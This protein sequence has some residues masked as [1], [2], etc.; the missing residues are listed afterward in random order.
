MA[1][2]ENWQSR[3]V[4]P[5][6]VTVGE[7]RIGRPIAWGGMGV[8]YLAENPLLG[9]RAAAKVLREEFAGE[10][11]IV[12]RFLEEASAASK[13]R[14]PN[15]VQIFDLVA[16]P[17]GRPCIVMEY[18]EGETLERRA[19]RTPMRLERARPIILQIC[20]ALSATHA[21]GIVHR[22]LKAENVLLVT[23]EGRDDFVKLLDFGLA[24]SMVRA[25]PSLTG[26]PSLP[27]TLAGTPHS[28][29]PEQVRGEPVDVRTDVYGLGV[30]S[31]RLLLGRFPFEG[32]SVEEVMYKHVNAQ[33]DLSM[34][35]MPL[36]AVLGRALAKSPASRF[37]T[38]VEFAQALSDC[39]SEEVAAP[40]P[41]SW[42]LE[43]TDT[44]PPKPATPKPQ[45]RTPVPAPAA[46]MPAPVP[47]SQVAPQPAAVIER[48]YSPSPHTPLPQAA[49][50]PAPKPEAVIER[51]YN[52][53]PAPS[54]PA[55]T[56][57]PVPAA[58][59]AR[60]GPRRPDTPAQ[61][62]ERY[63][64]RSDRDHYAF[65]GIDDDAQVELIRLACERAEEDLIEAKG[66]PPSIHGQV[67]ALLARLGR[68]RKVL[69]DLEAR[70]AYDARM[71][72]YKGVAQALA[73]GLS[74]NKL[75][76]LRKEFNSRFPDRIDRAK[77]FAKTAK[78]HLD[79][80][81]KVRAREALLQALSLDPL[82]PKL[83]K[84]YRDLKQS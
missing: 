75:E 79:K 63:R 8:I 47:T 59:P 24:K 16:L 26:G 29:S 39:G 42:M 82:S 27:G 49:P 5:C 81:D 13:I 57:T 36:A 55:P 31:Y 22:D 38:M 9:T 70:A 67:A 23:R 65:L 60:R 50:T 74:L 2:G 73:D 83:Q 20:G 14:H 58:A 33:P 28:M 12:E 71:S 11:A 84:W 76:K 80:R 51:V 62:L 21:R 10:A 30:L 32:Q 48:V 37:P 19:G 46:A 35:P 54:V 77:V 17:D 43:P 68:A 7:F 61:L 34:M 66:G 1:G 3:F 40:A 15:I 18:L 25:T 78:A 52:P 56:P 41:G 69:E 72:N 45:P 6:G 64:D 53:S 44:P 4:D